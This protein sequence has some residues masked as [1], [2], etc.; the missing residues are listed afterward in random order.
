LPFFL[1]WTSLSCA[2]LDSIVVLAPLSKNQI[3]HYLSV[4]VDQVYQWRKRSRG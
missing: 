3:T 1:I 4:M 2:G